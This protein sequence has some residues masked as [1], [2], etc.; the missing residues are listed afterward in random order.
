MKK[1]LAAA[2]AIVL[3]L[4]LFTGCGAKPTATAEPKKMTVAFCTWAGYG[5]LFIA[6]EKGYFDAYDY[7]VTIQLMEDES[8]YARR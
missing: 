6:K 8:A 5:P 1:I 2:A 4:S 7:D 3:A